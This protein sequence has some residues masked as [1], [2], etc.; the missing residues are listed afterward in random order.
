MADTTSSKL[1]PS[2][3]YRS[4]PLNLTVATFL[5]LGASICL[6]LASFSAP[7]I[8]RFYYL[9]VD[10]QEGVKTKF[11]TFGYCHGG[12]FE[13][14]S[15][16]SVGYVAAMMTPI[17]G[18]QYRYNIIPNSEGLTGSLVLTPIAA[19]LATIAVIWLA[20]S[21]FRRRGALIGFL[22]AFVAAIVAVLSFIL[23]LV[24]F[25]VAHRR[26]KR[27][28]NPRYGA[29]LWLHMSGAIALLLALPFL[30]L[31]WLR[32]RKNARQSVV[33]TTTSYRP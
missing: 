26:A 11:G 8:K 28:G 14:C 10:D 3:R 7:F 6:W 13:Q 19:G 33:T 15:S 30:L 21:W 31:A 18:S 12:E 22:L 23:A 4:F 29:A 20:V 5:T 1:A 27:A 32:Q 17:G 9:R 16:R 2:H 24:A 25:V